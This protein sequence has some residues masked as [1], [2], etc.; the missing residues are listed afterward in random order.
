V[1]QPQRVDSDGTSSEAR[2]IRHHL[3][4]GAVRV[5]PLHATASSSTVVSMRLPGWRIEGASASNHAVAVA[6]DPAVQRVAE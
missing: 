2:R 3:G 6:A 5:L 4:G 1:E